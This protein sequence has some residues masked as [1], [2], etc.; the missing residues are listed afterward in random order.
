[1]TKVLI[2]EDEAPARNKLK[3]FLSQLNDENK[4]VA[5]LESVEEA[6]EYFK[7]QQ[8]PDVVFSDIELRDTNAFEIYQQVQVSC[9]IIFTT[10]YNQFLMDAFE[11]NGIAYLLKPFSYDKFQK[12]WD[13]FK[14]F[15]PNDHQET[16][17]RI[18]QLLNSPSPNIIHKHK[19][20]FTIKTT[21]GIYFLKI[22]EILFFQANEG[23]VYA[24]DIAGK[25]HILSEPSLTTVENQL[26]KSQFFKINRSEVVNKKYVKKLERFSKNVVAIHLED[27]S[28]LLK[29]SQ[30][31][32]SSF[33]EWMGV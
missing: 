11:T 19:E 1:M 13:K 30:T 28:K 16:I 23:L 26:D 20:Q 5:E 7:N 4:V 14:Y 31:K 2:I 12:A 15:Q 17:I 8:H 10:A 9:P 3:R 33:N 29:T 24:H 18:Q 25:K 22:M 32:T 21:S 27:F 6:I